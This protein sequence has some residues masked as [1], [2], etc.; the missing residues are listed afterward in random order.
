[1][2][3]Q[4]NLRLKLIIGFAISILMIALYLTQASLLMGVERSLYD[5]YL[6]NSP[7]QPVSQ[8]IIVID[9]SEDSL[10][11]LGQWPW[12][13]YILADML[14]I[15]ADNGA[16]AVA[17][18]IILSEEDRTSPEKIAANLEGLDIAIDQLPE[19]RRNYDV[20][21]ANTIQQ[22]PAVLGFYAW[23]SG[24]KI[25]YKKKPSGLNVIWQAPKELVQQPVEIN[26]DAP[27]DLAAQEQPQ[28]EEAIMEAFSANFPIDVLYA[29]RVSTG[30]TN[31]NTDAD[32]LIRN[33]P[34]LNRLDGRIYPSLALATFMKA[35]GIKN[36]IV[37][38]DSLGA[39]HIKVGS[40]TIPVSSEAMMMVPF[41]AAGKAYPYYNAH[42]LLAGQ[43]EPA[44]LKDKIVL[45]GSSAVGLQDLRATPWD[46]RFPG[47]EVHAA[48]MDAIID[49]SYIITPRYVPF[50]QLCVILILG[51][52]CAFMFGNL[53]PMIYLPAAIMMLV[54]T[55]GL[56]YWLFTKGINISPAYVIVTIIF[57][58]IV[59]ISIRFWQEESH[60]R[61]IQNAF[62][63]Y[64]PPEVVASIAQG[65]IGFLKGQRKE[66][67]ILFSDIR[68]FTT[69]SEDLDPQQVVELLNE[70]F[71]PMTAAI[72]AHQGTTDKFIGD[73]IMA[74]WNAPL[75]VPK[76]ACM[77]VESAFQMQAALTQ[78]N[79]TFEAKYGFSLNMGIGI[80]SGWAYVGNM[81]SQEMQNYTVI[82]DNVN[83]A[84]RLEGLCKQY[85]V[86]FII[87]KD[88]MDMCLQEDPSFVYKFILLDSI[89]VKGRAH[90]IDIFQPVTEAAYNERA[91]ELADYDAARQ[92]YVSGNFAAAA[93][94][95][96]KLIEKYPNKM[97]TLYESRSQILLA[98]PPERWD[99]VW[100]LETK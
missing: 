58:A 10:A 98:N 14:K 62:G 67:S 77:A 23:Y 81:G 8:D 32:G 53:R 35:K 54:V 5:I 69:L 50:I 92:A 43:I 64:I 42:D 37:F 90:A 52:F 86:P 59:I 74:F 70:Y 11:A 49:G 80:H 100:I 13:R 19:E 75:D 45:I 46:G 7:K 12:P 2:N 63:K 1:M 93:A 82:G 21:L 34:L 66:L 3:K 91:A 41:K 22:T 84:S 9:I 99:G 36:A 16:A 56:S 40:Y 24:E 4:F 72:R 89:V 31:A 26:L 39:V 73:A 30:F 60:K 71:T 65:G 78:V 83:V 18:D 96:G 28:P 87:S 29:S 6:R 44:K 33:V 27:I 68:G 76:H 85:G 61:Y 20:Y 95:F 51:V 48:V 38:Y 15:L 97:Y 47:V 17:L 94:L 79:P 55:F 88:T 25:H 57:Q